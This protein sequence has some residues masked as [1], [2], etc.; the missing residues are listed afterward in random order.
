MSAM[1]FN[2]LD[3]IRA[4]AANDMLWA[5]RSAQAALAEDESKKNFRDVAEL[6][7]RLDPAL[8]PQLTAVPHELRGL[9]EVEEPAESF[10]R[11]RYWLSPREQELFDKIATMRDVCNKLADMRI[12]YLNSTLLYGPSGTGKTTF[13]R[14]VAHEFKLPF[15]YLNFSNVVDSLL[16]KTASNIAKVFDYARSHPCVFMLDEIDCVSGRREGGHGGVGGEMNR[17]TVSLMQELDKCG[18]SMVII[19]ATNRL[20]VVDEALLRRFSHHHEILYPKEA[21][22]AYKVVSAFLEDA[23]V[24]CDAGN[25]AAFCRNSLGNSQ[26]WLIARTIEA[27]AESIKTGSRFRYPHSA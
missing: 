16:G 24:D 5:R 8:N 1:T 13:G 10:I 18:G 23:S 25:V 27:L 26:S 4:I 19:A 12:S 21:S 14:F 22:E 3:V 20:D 15:Y 6:K 2:Q 17:I 11:E 7:R 9:I